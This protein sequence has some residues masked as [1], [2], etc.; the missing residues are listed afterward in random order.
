[1]ESIHHKANAPSPP[2]AI[3][4]YFIGL[5][6]ESGGV[7]HLKLQKLVYCAHGWW[8]FSQEKKSTPLVPLVTEKPCVWKYS[9]VFPSLYHVLK[10]HGWDSINEEQRVSPIDQ[11]PKIESGD[12][13]FLAF[14]RQVWQRYRGLSEWGMSELTHRKGTPWYAIAEKYDFSP[15]REDIAIDDDDIKE[16]FCRVAEL[17][18]PAPRG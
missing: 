14:L 11:P 2:L 15:P 17:S 5:S 18:S 10:I 9:P 8:L 6:V 16:E 4:N 13:E 7:K 1:M 3:A 12:E